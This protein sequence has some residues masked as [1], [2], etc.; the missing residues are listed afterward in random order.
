[1]ITL[2]NMIGKEEKD[3]KKE[4]YEKIVDKRSGFQQQHPFHNGC[5]P[6]RLPIR[7]LWHDLE[8]MAKKVFFL[9]SLGIRTLARYSWRTGCGATVPPSPRPRE[10]CNWSY[11]CPTLCSANEIM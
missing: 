6:T 10:D 7:V 5:G 11:L 3:R 9:A 8:N 1:M 4:K 2:I